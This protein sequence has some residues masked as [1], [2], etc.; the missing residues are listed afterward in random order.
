MI[1]G[2]EVE[3]DLGQYTDGVRMMKDYRIL[4]EYTG[5]M[6]DTRSD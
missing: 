1:R 2:H 5:E 3:P 4:P 6:D